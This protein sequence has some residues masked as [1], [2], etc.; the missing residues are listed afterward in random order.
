[1]RAGV[2]RIPDTVVARGLPPSLGRRALIRAIVF[3][4]PD[5]RVAGL[6]ES[7][8]RPRRALVRPGIAGVP[9]TVLA[10][11]LVAPFRLQRGGLADRTHGGNGRCDAA[12]V[13]HTG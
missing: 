13:R 2:L 1:M 3:G 11:P 9:Y 10:L 8:G 4:I 12:L 7:A 6:L 5:A